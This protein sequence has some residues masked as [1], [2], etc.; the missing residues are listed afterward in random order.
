MNRASAW[1]GQAREIVLDGE[2]A[3]PRGATHI[4]DLRDAFA[5]QGR[6]EPE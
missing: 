3:V 6:L 5:G 1:A 4:D 2:I